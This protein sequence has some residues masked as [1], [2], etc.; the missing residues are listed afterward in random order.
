[1]EATALIMSAVLLV[2]VDQWMKASVISWLPP[3]RAMSFGAVTIRTVLNR[4]VHRGSVRG[5]RVMLAWWLTDTVLVVALVPFGSFFQGILA[6]AALGAALGGATSNLLDCLWRD[7]VVDFVDLG[8][9]PVFNLA[10]LA[11]V[12]GVLIVVLCI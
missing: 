5:A 12:T 1:V 2:A 9:W 3:G 6:P 11:I 7:G 10:D 8:V 4:R